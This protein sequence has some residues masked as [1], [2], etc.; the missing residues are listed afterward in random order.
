MLCLPSSVKVL[1]GD[2][3]SKSHAIG[4]AECPK[5]GNA[6]GCVSGHGKCG[7]RKNITALLTALTTSITGN[8]ALMQQAKALPST[9]L[10]RPRSDTGRRPLLHEPRAYESLQYSVFNITVAVLDFIRAIGVTLR[11]AARVPS[12]VSSVLRVYDI[13]NFVRPIFGRQ[14]RGL[15]HGGGSRCG[16]N[17]ITAA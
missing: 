6:V 8:L 7:W 10:Q 17:N 12:R 5:P 13:A 14:C 4:L 3:V 11:Y 2:T 1:T 15:R 16:R 9:N